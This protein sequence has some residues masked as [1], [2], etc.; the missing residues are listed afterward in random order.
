[1]KLY[2]SCIGIPTNRKRG[3]GPL[4]RQRGQNGRLLLLW[5]RRGHKLYMGMGNDEA[6]LAVTQIASEF[7]MLSDRCRNTLDVY[8]A[9]ADK[10]LGQLAAPP[11]ASSQRA[12]GE[13]PC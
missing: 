5:G 6:L 1:M 3:P 4:R 8:R 9:I 13:E 11:K 2:V 10:A 7:G 12:V